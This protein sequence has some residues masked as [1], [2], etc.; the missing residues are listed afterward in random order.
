MNLKDV[1]LAKKLGNDF[2][3]FYDEL[4]ESQ[5]R[6][7]KFKAENLTRVFKTKNLE[8]SEEGVATFNKEIRAFWVSA[9]FF[10]ASYYANSGI[11]NG[12]ANQKVD[13]SLSK[14]I[15][16]KLTLDNAIEDVLTLVSCLDHYEV[17]SEFY[18]AKHLD[19]LG[20]RG[21]ELLHAYL[22]E[23]GIEEI[24]TQV[25]KVY[26]EANVTDSLQA[27]IILHFDKLIDQAWDYAKQKSLGPFSD[28]D[29]LKYKL[30]L[31]QAFAKR[32]S[33]TTEKASQEILDFIQASFNPFP[34]GLAD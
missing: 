31:T 13:T 12:I 23:N 4:S 1:R 22:A 32:A 3:E 16:N 19:T 14:S 27:Q 34:D 25:L 28:E 33:E 8:D 30:V 15:S 6:F 24:T 10:K 26:L 7:K 9:F 5:K 2:F 11:C 29:L 17:L 18:F 21:F 20:S